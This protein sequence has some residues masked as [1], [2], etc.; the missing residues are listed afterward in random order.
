M[1]GAGVI[2]DVPQPYPARVLLT[3]RGPRWSLLRKVRVGR[4]RKSPHFQVNTAFTSRADMKLRV[5]VPRLIGACDPMRKVGLKTPI[6]GLGRNR[7][8]Q[9][10]QASTALPL[11]ADVNLPVRKPRMIDAFDPI[12]TLGSPGG[13]GGKA[14]SN[15]SL[16]GAAR[17]WTYCLSPAPLP[18]I[19][20]TIS[21]DSRPRAIA[22]LPETKPRVASTSSQ[23]VVEQEKRSASGTIH[24]RI[25]GP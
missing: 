12:R 4:N 15:G 23:S 11:R 20:M 3:R 7:K 22:R 13:N 2:R 21:D 17:S 19:G 6:S 9:H 14:A 16:L 5:Q 18:E 8:S 10:F 1:S 25:R 24:S